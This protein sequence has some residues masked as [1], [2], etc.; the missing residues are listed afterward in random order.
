[1]LAAT[2]MDAMLRRLVR[3][4]KLL[5]IYPGGDLRSYGDGGGEEV[6]V[7]ITSRKWL[8][9]LL[10]ADIGLG[11]A[12]MDGGLVVERGDIAEFLVLLMNNVR[13]AD[14][15][16]LMRWL[17]ALRRATWR[18][19][20]RLGGNTRRRARRN[21]AHH[22]DLDGGLYDLFLDPDRQYSCA[23]FATPECDLE[24][25]QLA[26]KR[27]L[28]A[29]LHIR[30]GQRILDIGCGWGGLA[31]YLAQVY[32][33]VR[34]VGI[35]LS[36]EQ[37]EHARARARRAGLAD[38][39]EF[40][41]QDYRDITERFDRVVS[42]GMFEHVGVAHYPAFFDKVRDL[43]GNDGVAVLHSINRADGPGV[44]SR[45]IDRYI[46]PGG[47]IPAMSEV[48]PAIERSGLIISDVEILRL[49]Y[50][51]TL[52]HWRR[53]FMARRQRAAELYDDRFVR[54]WE[55]YLAASEAMFR[56]GL[57]NN[58]QIQM[59][60]DQQALP[61]TRDYMFEEERRLKSLDARRHLQ[62]VPEPGR[63]RDRESRSESRGAR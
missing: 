63:T 52:K 46:F 47:Y 5:V 22:Y 48:V 58:F 43:L 11:E 35:T 59:V 41:L 12:Y 10:D 56:S 29:K 6:R 62:V 2:M 53:R 4:G 32:E 45:W 37:L 25:A 7:R 17:D 44:T 33:D 27:H 30:P 54:M 31:L 39:V 20:V 34:V 19:P 14:W 21:V 55:F 51:E 38:R 26:K 16:P 15:P 24:E 9:K 28:A 49:H 36:T 61:L 40:R 18:L 3:R 23:Y 8:R 13:H 42:V 60:K 50:A 1:M 57:M